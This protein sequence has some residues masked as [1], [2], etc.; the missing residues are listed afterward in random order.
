M[1]NLIVFLIGLAMLSLWSCGG[2]HSRELT[3]VDSLLTAGEV[4]QAVDSLNRIDTLARRYGARD[5]NYYRLLKVMADDRSYVT[6]TTDSLIVPVIKYYES[7]GSDRELAKAYYY[8][9]SVYRDLGDAPQALDYFQ[10]A[11]D[12][13]TQS[14]CDKH[15]EGVTYSQ[16]GVLYM[17]QRVYELALK[18]YRK[19][20]EYSVAE[21]D[22]VGLVHDYSTIAGLYENIEKYD[23]AEYYFK[24]ALELAEQLKDERLV[25]MIDGLMVEL[26]TVGIKNYEEAKCHL[27]RCLY[28]HSAVDSA[29]IAYLAAIY[30]L[31]VG[32]LDS[33]E[34]Y[35]KRNLRIGMHTQ[36]MSA[37]TNLAEIEVAKGN[38]QKA[39]QYAQQYL[40][41]RN[42]VEKQTKTEEMRRINAMYN[43]HLRERENNKLKAIN[44]QN[45]R[46][47]AWGI[48]GGVIVL[49]IVL[50]Y[51]KNRNHKHKLAIERLEQKERES[52]KRYTLFIEENNHKID[53]LEHQLS[54]VSMLNEELRNK[55]EKQKA[56]LITANEVADYEIRRRNKALERIS[57]SS[58]YGKIQLALRDSSKVLSGNDW[59]ELEAEVNKSYPNF[60]EELMTLSYKLSEQEYH[61]CLL[62]KLN[63]TPS[64]IAILIC[65]TKESV[66]SIRRRLYNKVFNDTK[67]KPDYWDR[68][69]RTL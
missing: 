69:I 30:F 35:S 68:Y 33:A 7:H 54:D 61:V 4:S 62:L 53:E 47:I 23:S 46:I 38:T 51:L 28:S 40:D 64:N 17:G 63:I 24:K 52:T 57:G 15:L 44:E 43:Y 66:S 29:N 8:G 32:Q 37:Y 49:F 39:L 12:V 3:L 21:N 20:T 2:R 42:S 22:S 45:Q 6:H 67:G 55:I 5:M 9:G 16:M 25:P 10:K 34:I 13:L 48:V 18:M 31:E 50:L 41:Y 26:Y 27:D 59:K 36:K 19:S 56:A 60:K 14:G 58:I 65:R 1:K 11:L